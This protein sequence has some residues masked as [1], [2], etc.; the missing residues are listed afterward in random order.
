LRAHI[1][2]LDESDWGKRLNNLMNAIAALV[3]A[4]LSRFPNNVDHVLASHNLHG[5]QSLAS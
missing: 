1:G 5:D 2:R 3:K 4:E